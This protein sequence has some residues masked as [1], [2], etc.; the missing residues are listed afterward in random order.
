MTEK[1][2]SWEADF[3]IV[4]NPIR[5]PD[6]VIKKLYSDEVTIFHTKNAEDKLIYDPSLAQSQHV[7]KKLGKKKP[8]SGEIHSGN[9]ELIAKL[10]SLGVGHGLLPATIASQY[11]NLKR[12]VK[13]PIF[14]DEICLIYRPEKHRD[15]VGQEILKL[16]SNSSFQKN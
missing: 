1:V 15:R 10:T 3:G 14:N 11:S 13:S 4:V 12:L 2:I 5:H 9:L 16:I 7:L 8:F 6:L